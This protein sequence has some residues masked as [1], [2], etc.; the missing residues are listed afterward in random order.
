MLRFI[1]VLVFEWDRVWWALR[2][3]GSMKRAVMELQE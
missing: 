1:A 3:C 2:L